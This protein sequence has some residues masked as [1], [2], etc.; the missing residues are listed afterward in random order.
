L[1]GGANPNPNL[2]KESSMKA[3]LPL[4]FL[5]IAL[6]AAC[7]DDESDR[8]VATIEQLGKALADSLCDRCED[9]DVAE[10][11]SEFSTDVARN[12]RARIGDRYTKE[13]GA[14]CLAR[15]DAIS[16]EGAP[17]NCEG[18]LAIAECDNFLDGQTNGVDPACNADGTP[19]NP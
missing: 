16:C 2:L 17:V 6:A 19:R 14:A 10:C 8:P 3:A 15:I 9:A 5:F 12:G 13:M 1:R 18:N 4:A 11:K 7:G